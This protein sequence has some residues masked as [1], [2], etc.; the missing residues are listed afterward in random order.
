LFKIVDADGVVYTY[1]IYEDGGVDNGYTTW[2]SL[3]TY[4]R[5]DQRAKAMAHKDSG[6]STETL[7]WNRDSNELFILYGHKKACAK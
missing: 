2:D 6:R 5:F 4:K 7:Y 1:I 3:D